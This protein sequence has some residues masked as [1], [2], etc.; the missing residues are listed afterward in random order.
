TETPGQVPPT[1]LHHRGDPD[2]PKQVVAPGGLAV[3]DDVLPLAAPLPEGGSSGRRLA[4]ANWLTDPRHPLTARVIVNPVRMEHFRRGL[5]GPSGGFGRLGER[6]PHREL[7]DW[8]ASDF[9]QSGWSL[10]PLHRLILPSSAYRQSSTRPTPDPDDR[11]LGRF[12]VRRLDAE[13]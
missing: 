10:K 4:L 9:V 2:Q 6:P 12:P 13:A 1:R 11:L 8:L 3:L 5:V 7:L